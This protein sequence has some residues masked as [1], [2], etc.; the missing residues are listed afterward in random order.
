M[1]VD[2]PLPFSKPPTLYTKG[3]LDVPTRLVTQGSADTRVIH[4][5]ASISTLFMQLLIEANK[6]VD[7]HSPDSVA[8][9]DR[10]T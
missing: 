4:A 2:K 1:K 9:L 3:F 6:K 7:N 5:I 8:E 10:S